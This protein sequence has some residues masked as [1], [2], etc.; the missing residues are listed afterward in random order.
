MSEP[1]G[2]QP[3]DASCFATSQA[4]NSSAVF[5][6]G[7]GVEQQKPE[8]DV[9]FQNLIGMRAW[10]RLPARVQRRFSKRIQPALPVHY[11]GRVL[12]TRLNFFGWL[13]AQA[14]RVIGAPLPLSGGEAVQGPAYVEVNADPVSGDQIWTRHYDTEGNRQTIV[15]RKCFTGPTGLEERV[16]RHIGMTLDVV[17]NDGALEFHAQSYF[18]EV[19]NT[20]IVVPRWAAPGAMTIVHRDVGDGRFLFELELRHAWFGQ[21]VLQIAEFHDQH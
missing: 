12:E 14:S 11:R 17:E 7:L 13:L 16:T 21:M 19:F 6:E 20:R 10:A 18:L 8:L 4:P 15:S 9:R 1:M 3:T 5:R 2:D